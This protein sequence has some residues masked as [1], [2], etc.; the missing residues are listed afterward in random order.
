MNV[1]ARA[2]IWSSPFSLLVYLETCFNQTGW[3]EW[4]K[5]PL[6]MPSGCVLSGVRFVNTRLMLSLILNFPPF[7]IWYYSISKTNYSTSPASPTLW[8]GCLIKAESKSKKSGYNLLYARITVCK[9]K[10]IGTMTRQ[11]NASSGAGK[12]RARHEEGVQDLHCSV[13]TTLPFPG[14]SLKRR[15]EYIYASRIEMGVL[16]K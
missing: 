7:F 2:G 14:E 15:K 8:H 9:N 11:S 12:W 6:V 13:L 3:K 5:C 10:W 4:A 16:K 1:L